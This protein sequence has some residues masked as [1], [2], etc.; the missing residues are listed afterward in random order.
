PVRWLPLISALLVLSGMASAG[1]PGLVGFIAEFLVFQ[2]SYSVFPWQTLLCVV[3]SGLTAVYF[4]ILLN[5]T[6]FGRLDNAVAYFPKVEWRERVPAL[7]L[8]IAILFLGIQPTWLVRWS[9][10]TATEMVATLP[11][12][13]NQLI[14]VKDLIQ[15]M[16]QANPVPIPTTS[17]SQLP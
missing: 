10:A 11:E 13:S 6:C 7:M 4:V 15:D 5:R 14:A 12:A 9:E 3:G 1:I 8:A 16:A 2:G 17:L